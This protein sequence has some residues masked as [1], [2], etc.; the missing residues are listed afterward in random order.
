MSRFHTLPLGDEAT[1]DA[2]CFYMLTHPVFCLLDSRSALVDAEAHIR[3]FGQIK[4]PRAPLSV[5][6]QDKLDLVSAGFESSVPTKTEEAT[7]RS[8]RFRGRLICILLVNAVAHLCGHCVLMWGAC[9]SLP[10]PHGSPTVLHAAARSMQS[11][12]SHT[13]MTTKSWILAWIF[14]SSRPFSWYPP[15][16]SCPCCP[17]PCRPCRLPSS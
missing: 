3:D 2:K 11:L 4:L 8:R 17:W 12:P 14:V 7:S 6:M 15:S 1:M 10:N 16:L 13:R 9:C 5:G